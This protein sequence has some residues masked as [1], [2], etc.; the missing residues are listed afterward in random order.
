MPD[1]RQHRG[2]HPEDEQL[3]AAAQGPTLRRAVQ[4]FCWLLNHDYADKSA[5]KLVGDHFS[6]TQRQR[7]ALM[8]C[9]CS[10]QARRRRRARQ[11]SPENLPAGLLL[12]DG[13]NVLTTIE[14]ALAG[15]VILKA[16]D[17]CFRDLA[18]MHGTY[19]KVQETIPAIQLIGKYLNNAKISLCRWYLDK[20]VSN[21]GR[22]KQ[23]LLDLARQHDWNWQVELVF[24]PDGVLAR[25]PEIIAT[26]DG[27]ILN[28]CQRWFN[29]TREI[30]EKYLPDANIIKITDD[31]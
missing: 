15:G 9:S 19:R 7:M 25:T 28:H 18:G 21:S 12:L 3:F 31:T 13:Y 20:P 30:I 24:S 27:E 10:D 14:A 1:K 29:L 17:G 8:R 6:L 4:D 22:L 11:I 23:L 26:S 2:P 16:R 5:L